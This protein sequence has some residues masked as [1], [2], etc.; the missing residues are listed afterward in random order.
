MTDLFLLSIFSVLSSLHTRA[1]IKVNATA[2]GRG[3]FTSQGGN[4]LTEY[5]I[6]SFVKDHENT[7]SPVVRERYGVLSSCVAMVC[8]V[9][10][11]AV[12]L[13]LG[14]VSGSIAIT[15]DAFNNLSDVGSGVITFLGFKLA[16]QPSDEEHPF[17]HGRL[18]YISGLV[19]AFLVL[20]VGVEVV[21]SS[22]EKI[23][24]PEPVEFSLIVLAI[25]ILSI[26]LKLWMGHFNSIL[27]DRIDSQTMKA[28][29][30]DSISDC[31][32]TG[33]TTLGIIIA[34]ISGLQ[35]DGILGLLAGG[36]ILYAG[37]GIARDTISP[38]LGQ[39][40]DPEVVQEVEKILMS[41]DIVTN[42]HDLV[43]HDY[44]PG[45]MMGSAHVEVPQSLNLLTAHD[46]I[47]NA[48]R[49]VQS[50]LHMPF[51]IHLDPVDTE[52]EALQAIKHRLSLILADIDPQMTLHD[53]RMVS[54]QSHTNLIFDVLVPTSCHESNHALKKRIDQQVRASY[55]NYFTIITFDHNYM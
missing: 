48:E 47:D 37:Y 55:P 2:P 49:H 9:I 45:R 52:S 31:V 5:L 4:I 32:S 33:T 22:I 20:M 11:F 42:V 46:I 38:L 21:K 12:K 25:L 41:Y 35:L 28:A 6:R 14:L 53:F 40:P 1:M 18:E 39:R 3:F 24:H 26:L 36:F 29:A 16:S 10:L 7:A 27:G 17:G 30:A 54:G 8:N 23:I 44:G 19:I 13:I 34:R 50:A 43:I 15:A 51:V